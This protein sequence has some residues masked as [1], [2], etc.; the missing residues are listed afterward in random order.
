MKQTL[1]NLETQ[2]HSVLFKTRQPDPFIFQKYTEFISTG[3]YP[4]IETV[5]IWIEKQLPP[6]DPTQTR[7]LRTHVYYSAEKYR[8]ENVKTVMNSHAEI[9]QHKGGYIRFQG[10]GIIDGLE[11]KKNKHS[12]Y[13]IKGIEEDGAILLKGYRKHRFSVLPFFNQDQSFEIIGASE[14]KR[15]PAY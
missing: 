11:Q 13:E 9:E 3:Q 10:N 2:N 1:N 4:Y 7:N 8:K 12:F 15:L 6:L 5:S 14:Y